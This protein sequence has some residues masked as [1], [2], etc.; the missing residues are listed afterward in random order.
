M[1]R[2]DL[3][4]MYGAQLAETEFQKQARSYIL[5]QDRPEDVA[6]PTINRTVRTPLM[7]LIG[8]AGGV[9]GTAALTK[10]PWA[11]LAGGVAGGTLGGLAGHHFGQKADV[12][13]QKQLQW[14][15][16]LAQRAKT[17]PSVDGLG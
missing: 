11:R 5:G 17:L 7:G 2:T 8:A 4:R 16:D 12:K 3:A 1:T 10:N 15:L 6:L 14:L 9:G 13:V